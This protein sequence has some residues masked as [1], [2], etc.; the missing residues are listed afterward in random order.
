[1]LSTHQSAFII[2]LAIIGCIQE[3]ERKQHNDIMVIHTKTNILSIVFATPGCCK[4]VPDSTHLV[5]LKTSQLYSGPT[6]GDP[7]NPIIT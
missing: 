6:Y 4:L 7:N 1:M 5:L 2:S 3:L